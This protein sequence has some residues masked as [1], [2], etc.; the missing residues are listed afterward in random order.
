MGPVQATHDPFPG[1][2]RYSVSTKKLD[3]ALS[4]RP[5]KAKLD[6]SARL[7]PILLVHGTG[8]SREQN[9]SWNY[10]NQLQ[11]LG[12]EV[13]WVQL[14]GA[15]LN[16]IQISSE[17]VARAVQV[18]HKRTGEKVDVIGHSQ[19]GL[20]PR[21]AIR[22]F[23]AG[24][25]VADYIGFASPNHGTTVA[26]N[27]ATLGSCFA[28]CWQMRTDSD[29][30]AALNAGDETPGKTHY[31]NIYTSTDELVQP[32]GTQDLT[33]GSNI[34]LQDLCPERAVDHVSIAG[35]G[36]TYL[37]VMDALERRGPADP[38]RLPEGHC[39]ET[40]MPGSG[41]PPPAGLP[42]WSSYQGTDKE[43]PLKPYAR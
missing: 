23:P 15:S 22:F 10:W 21:W 19:G 40:A 35:D 5:S 30:M 41:S 25:F 1:N 43:P 37:L 7:Q 6:G 11:E 28:S 24:R 20:Q 34:L 16:D 17:Y 27:A 42:D 32:A 12:F 33:G 26:D 36:L 38:A 29:F 3:K 18:M 4:C 14:P 9:W 31:T 13:C 8:V 39:Q 2:A